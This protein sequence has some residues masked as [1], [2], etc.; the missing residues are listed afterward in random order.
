MLISDK[1]I[2]NTKTIPFEREKKS[3]RKFACSISWKNCAV[4]YEPES[5]VNV[6]QMFNLKCCWPF[7]NW[8][9]V[10]LLTTICY[11]KYT[12]PNCYIKMSSP[13]TILYDVAWND[14]DVLH[15][16]TGWKIC[17]I[18]NSNEPKQNGWFKVFKKRIGIQ[19]E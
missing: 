17:S 2:W 16:Q 14:S 4:F 19:N 7:R 3:A 9:F 18:C 6:K 10:H 5:T 12:R 13:I 11:P 8:C 15:I 1:I